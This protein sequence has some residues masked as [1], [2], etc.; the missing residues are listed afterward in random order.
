MP[1]RHVRARKIRVLVAG[2]A[3]HAVYAVTLAAAPY[4]LDMDVA[5]IA[6]Q[7]SV[8]GGVAVLTTR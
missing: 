3:G 2:V 5:I 4:V 1:G 6:L 8:A 7:R